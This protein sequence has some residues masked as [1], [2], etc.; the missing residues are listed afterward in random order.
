MKQTWVTHTPFLLTIILLALSFSFGYHNYSEARQRVISDLNRALRHTVLHNSAQ[1]LSR[2]TLQTC[3]HLQNILGN[4]VTISSSNRAFTEALTIRQL[5][6][7]AG[8]H[9]QIVKEKEETTPERLSASYIT[10]DTIIWISP[11]QTA[12]SANASSAYAGLSFRG[13]AHCTAMALWKLSDQTGPVV[14][15]ILSLLSGLTTAYLS[16]KKEPKPAA[17]SGS[18]IKYG[19]LSLSNEEN[20]FYDEHRKRLKLTP[21]QFTLMEM[22]FQTPSHQLFKADI[23]GTLWPGKE[24]ADETLYTLIRRL[25]PIIEEHS[26]LKITA[27][28][29][30]AYALEIAS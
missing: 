6:K 9:I 15:F 25:K 5:K 3:T 13:Y 24:N 12:T 14:L 18:I 8:I 28:R 2:D 30:R 29:G 26:N 1:W 11:E 10:S 20:C 4:T 22:F 27:D 23:C 21:L 19:N 7:E 17:F 16:R